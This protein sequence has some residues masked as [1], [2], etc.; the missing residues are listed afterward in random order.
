MRLKKCDE[1]VRYLRGTDYGGRLKDIPVGQGR[2]TT[3]VL[4]LYDALF[5]D[6][7]TVMKSLPG[8]ASQLIERLLL[9]FDAENLKTILRGIWHGLSPSEVRPLLYRLDGL[10]QLPV[11]KL[12]EAREV[13]GAVELLTSTA[14]HTPLKQ[15]LGQ[16]NR[17]KRLFPLEIAAD[18]AAVEHV[19]AFL[20]EGRG[21]D[22]KRARH[23]LGRWI[24]GIN[25]CWMVRFRHF[26]GFSPEEAIHYTVS[27]GVRLDVPRLGT[28]A[29]A[30][31]L[32]EFVNALPSPYG[33]VL[34]NAADWHQITPLFQWWLVARLHASF[35]ENPFQVGLQISYLLLK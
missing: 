23:L 19:A 32:P 3:V 10:S 5:S 14:F 12:L 13:N 2:T 29:R 21:F 7:G 28:L 26:Y 30:R 35:L 16:F 25:L 1:V 33:E 27:G 18:M 4:S 11:E 20:R 15:A 6:Y 34:R 22:G 17:Q 24:D 31:D 8:R 9:R